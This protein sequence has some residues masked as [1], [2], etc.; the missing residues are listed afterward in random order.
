VKWG[1]ELPE[2]IDRGGGRNYQFDIIIEG[3][4]ARILVI[5][6]TTEGHTRKIA[7]YIVERIRSKGHEAEA[8]DSSSGSVPHPGLHFD[9]CIIGGSVHEGKHQRSLVHFVQENLADLLKMPTAFFSVSLA[10]AVSDEAHRVE[11]QSY[12]DT[13]IEQTEW[14]PDLTVSLAGALLYT[15]Y[16]FFK[17]L[18]MKFISRHQGGETDTSRDYEYTDWNQIDGFVD[19]FLRS[20]LER[21]PV[22]HQAVT[23]EMLQRQDDI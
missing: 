17:R 3:V 1:G 7:H 15:K 22:L 13:F 20:H 16:D 10:A 11:T 2:V 18:L 12:I 4:M 23:E 6:G 8:A 9:G 14:K 5:Y 21:S 19:E